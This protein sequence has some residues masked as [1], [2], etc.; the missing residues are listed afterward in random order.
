VGFITCIIFVS[1]VHHTSKASFCLSCHEMEPAG[2]GWR[3]S[4][5]YAN[6]QGIVVQCRDCHIEPGL[7]GEIKAEFTSGL[8]DFL[9][10]LFQRPKATKE[11]REK[12]KEISRAKISDANCRKCHKTLIPPGIKMGGIIAHMSYERNKDTLKITCLKCHYH[13]FHG[14][15]PAYGTL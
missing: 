3:L 12:W 11:L 13:T 6:R 10:H 14:P 9:V 8:K 4:A 7:G 1:I 15:K 2:K 5:H